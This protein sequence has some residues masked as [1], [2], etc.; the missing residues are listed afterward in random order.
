MSR[1][2]R[3]PVILQK[4]VKATMVDGALKVEGP[5]GKLETKIMPGFTVQISDDRI[6]V[7]RSGD[8]K[9]ERAAHGLM[10]KQLESL[11]WGE[12]RARQSV[13]N[14]SA[15]RRNATHVQGLTR[16]NGIRKFCSAT[17]QARS[18]LDARHCFC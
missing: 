15:T 6:E 16:V 5:K 2:G 7:K 12:N 10:R 4:G 3:L 9:Q 8:E 13:I 17:I 11:T 1:I 18:N 14:S